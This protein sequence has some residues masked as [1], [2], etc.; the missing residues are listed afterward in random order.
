MAL[1][2]KP[3][4]IAATWIIESER[5]GAPGLTGTAVRIEFQQ[6]NPM[7]RHVVIVPVKESCDD[8]KFAGVFGK[9]KP[10]VISVQGDLLL[11]SLGI[12]ARR[13]K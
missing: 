6:I 12:M 9:I 8:S 7:V 5:S 2:L 11:C 13:K 10:G 1:M 3:D 4:E